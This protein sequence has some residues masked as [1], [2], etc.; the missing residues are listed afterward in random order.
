MLVLASRISTSRPVDHIEREMMTVSLCARWGSAPAVQDSSEVA[1]TLPHHASD[2]RLRCRR[3]TLAVG[4]SPKRG[5][6]CSAS[7][8][9]GVAAWNRRSS[10][11]SRPSEKRD[12]NCRCG[13]YAKAWARR[14]NMGGGPRQ[15]TLGGARAARAVAAQV[16]RPCLRRSAPCE[17]RDRRDG[18]GASA[19]RA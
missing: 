11:T 8:P 18:H 5:S 15:T 1:S 6:I 4:A 10:P 17:R 9:I 14:A 19:S 7:A 13:G 16:R 3:R 12:R 2:R